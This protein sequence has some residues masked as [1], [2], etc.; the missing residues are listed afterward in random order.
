MTKKMTAILTPIV[1]KN[2][3]IYEVNQSLKTESEMGS[4]VDL[5]A[6]ILMPCS[7][8]LD[9]SMSGIIFLVD[10]DQH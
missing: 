2:Y 10:V 7:S 6:G 5:L 8:D 3:P 4:F 9:T 1:K